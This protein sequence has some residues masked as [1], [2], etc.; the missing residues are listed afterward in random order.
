MSYSEI[1]AEVVM[2]SR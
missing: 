2:I 1:I